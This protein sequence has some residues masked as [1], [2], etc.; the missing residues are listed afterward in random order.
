[1]T[2]YGRS[3]A[4]L[5]G[6]L[7]VVTT[8]SGA[9]AWQEDGSTMDY[10]LALAAEEGG[11]I[12]VADRN[13]PGIWKISPEGLSLFY[14]GEKKFR[15]PLNAIRCLAID[16][17]GKL[18]A[19][20]TSTR[21]VYRFSAEGQPVA[22]TEG[23]IGMPMALAVGPEGVIYVADL[24]LHYI[25]KVAKEGGKPE[26]FAEVPAPRGL[27]F[28][29]DGR[30]WVVSGVKNKNQLVRL[31]TDGSTEVVVSG[32]P[33]SFPHN[34]ALDASGSAYVTDGFGKAV[35]KVAANSE[36]VKL[37]EGNGLTNPVGIIRQG[38]R[39]LVVDPHAKTVFQIAL[40]GTLSPLELGG[41]PA[42]EPAAEPAEEPAEEPA[43]DSED[44]AA[45]GDV[46]TETEEKAEP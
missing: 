32:T 22:L 26:K 39:L 28:D 21:E 43:A 5:I 40:D 42:A 25:W 20:D 6:L 23:G 33:F 44:T 13:L 35:W 30:L 36:P 7:L 41:E 1:M 38:E 18:L 12:F 15:T 24:E 45:E 9:R 29:D 11:D 3:F 27:A 4:L 19:G 14:Q 17:E 46:G 37:V 31:A 8:G 10:P 16:T 2:S 34:V